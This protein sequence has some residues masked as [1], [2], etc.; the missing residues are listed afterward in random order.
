VSTTLPDPGPP[1]L[2]F[3]R[4]ADRAALERAKAGMID[5]GVLATIADDRDHARRLALE[6]I[7]DGAEVH[8]ALS[9]TLRELGI[10]EEIDES[11]RYESVR[12]KLSAFDRVT[13]RREMAK[14]G[15]APDYILGSAHAITEGGEIVV[16]SGSGSQLGAYAYAGGHVILIVGHQKIVRDL[17]EG[18]RRLREYSLPREFVRMQSLGFPGTILAKTLI[19]HHE[20]SSRISVILVPEALGF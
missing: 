13:Q 2:E 10:T 1:N 7:P 16:G 6:L 9:E 3:E 20:P 12:S 11:G 15:A 17:D 8:V 18:L 5:R 19:I 4:P 14:L